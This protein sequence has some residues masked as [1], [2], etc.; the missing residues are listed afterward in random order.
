MIASA[1]TT[2]EAEKDKALSAIR[3]EVVELSLNAASKV[4]GRNVGSEDDRRMVRELVGAPASG[5]GEPASGEPA[6]GG[7]VFGG[8]V[9][10]GTASGGTASGGTAPEA[11]A[12]GGSEA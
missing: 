2:I 10:G 8:T 3:T 1:R 9:S 7:T 11:Q 12:E 4:L 5:S 6:S